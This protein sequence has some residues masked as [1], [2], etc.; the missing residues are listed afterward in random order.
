MNATTPTGGKLAAVEAIRGLACL[1]VVLSHLALVFWPWLHAFWG[2]ADP[3]EHPVQHAV[4]DAP[5][6]FL[7]SGSTAVYVFFVLS[8]FILTHV[9]IDRTP[10]DLAG[11]VLKRYP[12]LALPVLASCLFAWALIALASVDMSDLSVW[13]QGYGDFDYSLPGAIRNALWEAFVTG[14]SRYNPVLWTM[15]IELLGSWLVFAMCLP[16]TRWPR[17]RAAWLAI[18]ALS[19][20]LAGALHGLDMQMMLGLMS[21]VVG[22]AIQQFGWP[23]RRGATWMVLLAGLYLAGVH[24]TSASYAWMHFMGYGAYEAGNFIAGA[25]IVFALVHDA[26]FARLSAGRVPL[27][28]GKVS[29]AVYLVHLA[30][31]ASLGVGLFDWLYQDHDWNYDAAAWTA[32]V[33]SIV[34]AYAVAT[35]FHALVDAPAITLSNRFRDLLLP[36]RR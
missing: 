21:F 35:L 15:R 4:H 31:V 1:Q 11:L 26:A 23:L 25:L 8:G 18:A 34:V 16:M 28:L 17:L 14:E 30:V 22:A 19:I 29:F 36:R 33:A 2:V 9:A 5:F 3:V 7:Y 20:G 27:F 13:I 24:V 32:G 10:R 6:G 12:R